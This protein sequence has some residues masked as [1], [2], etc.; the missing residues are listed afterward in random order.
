M[1]QKDILLIVVVVI[2]SGGVSLFVSSLL[3][4]VPK[5][6]ET[7]VEVVQP[8]TAEFVQP[9]PRYFNNTSIDPTQNISIGGNQ[10][11]AP[12]NDKKQ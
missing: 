2:I 10:N 7:K 1:K 9:D 8:I 4:K 3:F 6:Q 5:A 11:P 12:F